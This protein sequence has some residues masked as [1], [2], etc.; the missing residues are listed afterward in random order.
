MEEIWKD[1]EGYEGLYQISNLGRVKSLKTNKI[2][3]YCISK[4]GYAYS[5]LTKNKII[6]Q[7]SVH[8]LV[9][10]AFISNPD[11]LEEINHKDENKLNN[12]VNN[13]EWCSHK[14]NMNY[15]TSRDK[16]K[17]KIICI[18]TNE[19]FNSFAEIKKQKNY[20]I[21]HICQCCKGKRKSSQGLHWKYFENT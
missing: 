14:Y 15:G 7:K 1:I 18:E 13:L 5:S 10:K 11:N 16:L 19:I 2:L 3:K 17:R 4:T 12:N 21:T 20:N 9:A 6:K 8:R